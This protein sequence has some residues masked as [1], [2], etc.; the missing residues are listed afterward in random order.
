MDTASLEFWTILGP[1]GILFFFFMRE[2][3]SYLKLKT[4]KTNGNTDAIYSKITAEKLG[5]ISE[6]HLNH[7]QDCIIDGDNRIV[8]K[9]NEIKEVLIRMDERNI[10]R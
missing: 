8:S 7:I 2:F 4:N 3:F 9:L 10:N 5:E 1:I 6:N